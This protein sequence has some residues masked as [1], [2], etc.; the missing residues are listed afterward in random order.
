MID[1]ELV[2]DASPIEAVATQ[3][4]QLTK[5]S[6]R[7]VGLCPLHSESRGSFNVYYETQSWYCYGCRK[8]GDVLTLIMLKEGGSFIEALRFLA[9]RANAIKS[10]IRRWSK[11]AGIPRLHAHL[12]RHTFATN[13]LIH[14]CGDVFRL[15]KLLGHNSLEMVRRYVHYASTQALINSKTLSPVD[16]MGIKKL[17]AYKIDQMLSKIG[18]LHQ[19]DRNG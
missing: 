16:Q 11:K 14:N 9:V 8:V 7:L 19:K 1:I 10:L 15:Q 13:Y 2:R 3:Y 4:T 17:R 6:N 12:C 18:H 5:I